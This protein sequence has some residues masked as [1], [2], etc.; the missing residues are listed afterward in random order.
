MHVSIWYFSWNNTVPILVFIVKRLKVTPVKTFDISSAKLNQWIVREDS[1]NFNHFLQIILYGV[2]HFYRSVLLLW[3][4]NSLVMSNSDVWNNVVS[5]R[6]LQQRHRFYPYES[7]SDRLA[8]LTW[9]NNEEVVVETW[10]LSPDILIDE[11]IVMTGR[12]WSSLPTYS[13]MTHYT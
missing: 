2:F 7:F 5:I 12:L 10:H 3:C 9:H 8:P 4:I 11:G 13:S 6:R 1:R